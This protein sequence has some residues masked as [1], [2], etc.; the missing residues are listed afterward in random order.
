MTSDE[1]DSVDAPVEAPSDEPERVMDGRVGILGVFLIALAAG[2]AYVVSRSDEIEP[3]PRP[4]TG[5]D[6]SLV[7]VVRPGAGGD[8]QVVERLTT[9]SRT[10]T[11]TLA[12]PPGGPDGSDPAQVT[13][14]RVDG[15]RVA[16]AP[17]GRRGEWQVPLEG[18]TDRARLTYTL[19]GATTRRASAPP[20]R[21]LVRV[22]PLASAQLDPEVDVVV[23]VE[24]VVVRNL[25]CPDLPAD[26]QL[27]GRRDGAGWRTG[28]LPAGRSTVLAQVDLPTQ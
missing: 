20:G 6:D 8:V 13:G 12:T 3:G 7:V 21:A 9:A 2:G 26:R 11:L 22:R 5:R 10:V 18:R 1:P 24:G 23:R 4:P 17:P 14:L 19:E 28:P 15:R 16:A 27:C 25:V